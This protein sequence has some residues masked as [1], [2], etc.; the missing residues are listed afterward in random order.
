MFDLADIRVMDVGF[1][2]KGRLG[3]PALLP[4]LPEGRP[5]TL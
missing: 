5:Q 1:G 2:G 4:V 3:Q